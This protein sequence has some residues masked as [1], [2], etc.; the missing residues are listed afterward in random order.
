MDQN[1]YFS[2]PAVDNP[3]MNMLVK[4]LRALDLSTTTQR[5]TLPTVVMIMITTITMVSI[6]FDAVVTSL[7]SDV[8]AGTESVVVSL[9]G[10]VDICP[11]FFRSA[12]LMK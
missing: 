10:N 5:H 2:L 3:R 8:S 11:I 4:D 1:A 6:A 9:N 7:Y 12:K